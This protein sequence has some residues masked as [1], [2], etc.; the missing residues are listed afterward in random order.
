M[1]AATYERYGPPETIAIR[2][3]P[4]PV[5]KEGEVLVRVRAASVN[6]WDWDLLTGNMLGRT[7]GLFRPR[8]SVL[9]A[10]IAGIVEAVGPGV[11]RFRP[12]DAVMGDL[13]ES[14]WGGFAQFTTAAEKFLVH[15]PDGL[16]FT[17]AAAL[18]QAGMLALQAIRKGPALGPERRVLINGAGGGVGSFA[19]QLAKRAGAEVTA[20]DHG[21]K[22]DFMR[23]L[24]ADRTLDYTKAN[25]ATAGRLQDLV[26]DMVARRPTA[27]HARVLRPEGRFV[28]VGGSVPSLIGTAAI[29][30]VIS[31]MGKK[32]IGL[33]L[34]RPNA[35]DLEELAGLAASGAIRVAVDTVYPLERTGDALRQ[36][37][38]GRAKGKVVVEVSA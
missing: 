24:G 14:G 7:S 11:T 26:I 38:E 19:I 25:Y 30:S 23:S 36:V 21:D 17:D 18:P 27:Q 16:G 1:K 34:Y 10:D 4:A 29:G 6:S 32:K 8:Y 2:D 12:G 33:L 5:P 9:G 20:V 15:K 31:L 28:V 3:V 22:L 37:G 35:A 13:S